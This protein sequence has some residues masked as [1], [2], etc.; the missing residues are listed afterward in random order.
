MLY[1][2]QIFDGL[3][4]AQARAV[5][6]T[7]GPVL[8]IAGPGSG[9]TLT[10]V[11]RIAYLVSKGIK[12]EDIL[13]VT[14]TN[15]AA[16]EMK[17]R[18]EELLK[19]KSNC[20]FIGTF[21]LLGLRI[22]QDN[23]P[24]GFSILS[25]DEQIDL[26]RSFLHCSI[27]DVRHAVEKISRV[28]N[29]LT[30][31]DDETQKIY[32]TYEACLRQRN[33]IDIDDL[34]LKPIAMLENSKTASA[35]RSKYQH[36]IVDE[37]QDINPAQYRLLKLL[38]KNSDSLYAVGD[39]DQAIYSF[40]GA[41]I[42]NFL[43][44]EKDFADAT[45]ITLSENYRSSG[46][47]V[48]A[49]NMVIKNNTKR[50]DK[51]LTTSRE[52]GKTIAIISVPDERVEGEIIV[53]EIEMRMCGTSHYQMVKRGVAQD[54]SSCTFRFSDFGVIY[55]TNAQAKA[56]EN[57]F[58]SSGIPFQIIGSRSKAKT[59]ENDATIAFLQ[60][61][62][63]AHQD[64]T[65]RQLD[66]Q[67]AKLIT[68]EDFFDYRADAVTLMTIHM[69]KGLEFPV[70]F[71]AGVEDGLMPC[72]I[73]QDG[74]DIEEERRLCYVGMTRAENELIMLHVR[75]RFLYG[76]RRTLGPSPFLN[77][78]PARFINHTDVPDKNRKRTKTDRQIKLL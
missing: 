8:V 27:K 69:A 66:G 5:Q 73:I 29:F 35:C 57:T 60:S 42:D 30:T 34:I 12:P 20:I 75:T 49:A 70:V 58:S 44:F 43:N 10:I 16:R 39:A 37:Y 3:N 54:Y 51:E 59:N 40:R 77:E 78:L 41:V 36:V 32:T 22:I 56:L 17:G 65:S 63:L 47:I 53:R 11:R 21:H 50:V 55:R 28:K 14:F 71:M 13:A 76:R 4:K 23:Q 25:R 31:A 33:A 64:G 72:T 38:T 26:F 46:A 48:S 19:E 2:K 6:G 7:K 15:R 52:R 61:I 9:K 1:E 62:M 24:T 68:A 67:E 74:V 18:I 45:R